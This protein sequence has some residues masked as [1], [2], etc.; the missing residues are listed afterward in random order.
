LGEPFYHEA[1][2]RNRALVEG[3]LVIVKVCAEEQ[4][5]RYGRVLAWVYKDGIDVGGRLLKERSS[6]AT[7]KRRCLKVSDCGG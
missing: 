4:R 6:K 1:K 5:D 3:K 7:S 2:E